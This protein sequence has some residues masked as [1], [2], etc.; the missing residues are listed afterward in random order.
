MYEEIAFSLATRFESNA[1]PELPA[2]VLHLDAL[3]FRP[4][5]GL[6]TI[7]DVRSHSD[8]LIELVRLLYERLVETDRE[9]VYVLGLGP[10]DEE[11]LSNPD[12][13]EQVTTDGLRG[14]QLEFVSWLQ[15]LP[16]RMVETYGVETLQSAPASR[17]DILSNGAVCLVVDTTPTMIESVYEPEAVEAYLHG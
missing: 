6:N 17:V 3:Y 16:P 4:R 10:G 14:D 9:P 5:D 7:D 12:F 1:V 8:Q 2:L 13:E 15:I 11:V